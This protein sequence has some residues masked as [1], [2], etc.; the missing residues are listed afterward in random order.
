[1]KKHLL[2]LLAAISIFSY[3]QD[4]NSTTKVTAIENFKPESYLG[5]WYEIA[6]IPFY[7]E[8]HC[9]A[10]VT[11]NYALDGNNLAV[12]NSCATDDGKIDVAHG[13]AYF[14]E[15]TPNIAKLEVTFVPSWLR[16]THIGR[17]DYWVLYTDYQ[18]SLV[19][20]PNHKYLWIL[21]RTETVESGML[22]QL[23]KIAKQQGFDTNKLL[24]NYPLTN[25]LSNQN[26]SVK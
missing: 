17:G 9:R 13:T 21:S 1:M 24:F 11:A 10:P 15:S 22:N 7:F 3:A 26:S 20:S 19:G 25:S 16:F 4:A 6:R 2:L 23:L 5:S 18:Y 12:T 8:K 14:T